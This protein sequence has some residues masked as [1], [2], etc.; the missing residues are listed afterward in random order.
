M[1][2]EQNREHFFK[3]TLKDIELFKIIS[4]SANFNVLKNLIVITYNFILPFS[5]DRSFI[6]L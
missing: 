4:Y 6:I 3:M 5:F 1:N 2:I